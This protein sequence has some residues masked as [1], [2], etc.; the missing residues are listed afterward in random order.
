MSRKELKENAAAVDTA[1]SEPA[2]VTSHDWTLAS[3]GNG[4]SIDAL[5]LFILHER[6]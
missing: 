4:V 3:A 2:H 5:S 1:Q 6:G